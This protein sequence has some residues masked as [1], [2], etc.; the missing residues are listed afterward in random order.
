MFSVFSGNPAVF[1]DSSLHFVA[2]GCC[3]TRG[4]PPP[5]PPPHFTRDRNRSSPNQELVLSLCS[6]P[7]LKLEGSS[8]V[9]RCYYNSSNLDWGHRDLE[10]CFLTRPGA[11]LQGSWEQFM[12]C[13]ETRQNFC[14]PPTPP[15]SFGFIAFRNSQRT[16]TGWRKKNPSLKFLT[17]EYSVVPHN[18][19]YS[20][21][22][23]PKG[24]SVRSAES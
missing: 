16:Y 20:L 12:V 3:I 15:L 10:T 7:D 11:G 21:F 6:V 24:N 1:Q 2:L 9:F 8:R 14:V 13:V 5:P 4:E 18:K 19:E 17:V 23:R 22:L